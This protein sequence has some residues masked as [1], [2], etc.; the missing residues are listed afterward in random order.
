MAAEI[1]LL[2]CGYSARRSVRRCEARATMLARDTDAQGGP[3]RQREL[4]DRHTDWLRANRP[5]VHDLIH[6]SA[7][8]IRKRLLNIGVAAVFLT[9]RTARTV[10]Q[11]QTQI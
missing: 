3:L 11:E 7:E 9:H 2:I 5:N 1:H 10:T 4:C 8:G 6:T